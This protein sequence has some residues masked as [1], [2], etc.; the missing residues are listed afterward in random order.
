MRNDPKKRGSMRGLWTSQVGTLVGALVLGLAAAG[1]LP[2]APVPPGRQ[3][4]LIASLHITPSPARFPT[5][6]PPYWPMPK[7]PVTITNNG[8]VTVGSIV[9]HPVGVYS[10][11]STTCTT[12]T[13]G[14]SC[15]ADIQFCPTSPYHYVNTLIV[16]GKNVAT[17][18]AVQAKITLDGTAT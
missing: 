3:P 15:V 12:L 10:V 7:V 16:T 6:P 17:G 11:P 9:V 18:S 14:H 1:C 2:I 8:G 4:P 13:P 5:T